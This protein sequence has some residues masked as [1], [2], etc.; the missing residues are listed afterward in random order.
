MSVE[1]L[2][3]LDNLKPPRLVAGWLSP[4]RGWLFWPLMT[5]PIPAPFWAMLCQAPAEAREAGFGWGVD[6]LR[7][8]GVSRSLGLSG[9]LAAMSGDRRCRDART[10]LDTGLRGRLRSR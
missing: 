5:H 3:L 8:V 2:K 10:V 7:L 6:P 4:L 9:R 1:A